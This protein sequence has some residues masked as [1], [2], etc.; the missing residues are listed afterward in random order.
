MTLIICIY[1]FIIF[2]FDML[3]VFFFLKATIKFVDLIYKQNENSFKKKIIIAGSYVLSFMFFL[4]SAEFNIYISL[5]NCL[6]TYQGQDI[7]YKSLDNY[8]HGIVHKLDYVLHINSNIL[9]FAIGY[10]VL[11]IFDQLGLNNT[12]L[13][14]ALEDLSDVISSD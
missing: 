4:R 6:L 10:M 3:V 14:D 11:G 2:T 8:R 5:Q 13:Y 9:T 7:T 12:T 1:S